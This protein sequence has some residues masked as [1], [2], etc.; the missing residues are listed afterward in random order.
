MKDKTGLY[1]LSIV[2]IVAL[3]G[4]VVLILN[5]TSSSSALS[6]HDFSG[7]TI[8]VRSSVAQIVTCTDSDDG[9]DYKTKGRTSGGSID[10]LKKD[11]CIDDYSLTE[12][13][14]D[15]KTVESNIV[16]CNTALGLV[17]DDGYEYPD[18]RWSAQCK[19][20]ACGYYSLGSQYY[21]ETENNDAD[22]FFVLSDFSSSTLSSGNRYFT[23]LSSDDLEYK[24]SLQSGV[25]YAHEGSD[26]HYYFDF[27]EDVEDVNIIKQYATFPYSRTFISAMVMKLDA[28]VESD[29]I[30]EHEVLVAKTEGFCGYARYAITINNGYYH[31]TISI[32]NHK[33]HLDSS[34]KVDSNWHQLMGTYDGKTVEFY[35]SGNLEDQE[36]VTQVLHEGES[37][38][39]YYNGQNVFNTNYPAAYKKMYNI[40]PYLIFGYDD[41]CDDYDFDGYIDDVYI[42]EWYSG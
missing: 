11:E 16:Q 14:C 37:G 42:W 39:L 38:E 40:V 35:V 15:G 41:S 20:G 10:D 32:G 6:T 12:Y 3:V 8:N 21:S 36:E 28:K 23:S 31:F 22:D 19:E 4:V 9:Q 24:S 7:Q 26:G 29:D 2:G 33:Y 17:P 5:S 27:T 18:Y 34:T 13:Y 1:L 30:E 25:V